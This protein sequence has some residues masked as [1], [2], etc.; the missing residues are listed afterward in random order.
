MKAIH[1]HI[2]I[3]APLKK[4]FDFVADERNEPFYNPRMACVEK[5]THGPVGVGS[6]FKA[7]MSGGRHSTV[8]I[9]YTDFSPPHSL[10]SM[11]RMPGMD[12]EGTLDFSA[13]DGLTR[14]SWTWLLQPHGS[15]RLMSP[16]IRAVGRRQER[17]NWAA[18]KDFLEAG[19]L[20]QHDRVLPFL[21]RGR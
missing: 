9:E 21:R 6:R 10:T 4:V 3:D 2:L 15:L 16:V 1:A 12:I 8:L 18:L 7:T 5:T 14:L 20:Q 13:D 11:S 19:P 17:R